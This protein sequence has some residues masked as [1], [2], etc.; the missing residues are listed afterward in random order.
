MDGNLTCKECGQSF[1]ALRSLHSHL[2]VHGMGCPEY[3]VK[4]FARK[5]LLTGELLPFKDYNSYF[6]HDFINAQQM[7]KWCNENPAEIVKP[8]ILAKLKKRKDEKSLEYAPSYLDLKLSRMPSV[9]SYR[10]H[11]GSYAL[12]AKE[13]GLKIWN[14]DKLP[15]DFLSVP[16]NLQILIDTREQKPLSFANSQTMKLDL[17]DYTIGSDNYSYTYVDRKSASDFKGTMT[18]G[19]ERFQKE[20]ERAREFGCFIFVVIESSISEIYAQNHYKQFHKANLDFIW[21][22]LKEMQRNYKD[23]CQFIFSGSREKSEDL[24]P[25]ILYHG[26]KLWRVDMQYYIDEVLK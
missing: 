6:E 1:A 21:H 2:K 18:L 25:K 9:E 5:N 17:G 22:Q 13:V 20:M 8:Y 10:K 7:N 26:K 11:F 12:A 24:I 14:K 4:N 23:C 15:A 16:P 19:Y 3:Y